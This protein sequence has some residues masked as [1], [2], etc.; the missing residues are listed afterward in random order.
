MRLTDRFKKAV[1]LW[2]PREAYITLRR[3]LQDEGAAESLRGVLRKYPDAARWEKQGDMQP[4]RY[5]LWVRHFKAADIL[6]EHTPS[7]LEDKNEQGHTLLH[8]YAQRCDLKPLVFLLRQGADMNARDLHGRTALHL[9]CMQHYGDDTVSPL[10][11]YGA[12]HD[13]KDR[14]GRTPLMIALMSGNLRAAKALMKKPYSPTQTDIFGR[15][16]LMAAA[17]G[18]MAEVIPA[19]LQSGVNIRQKNPMGETALDLALRKK[20]GQSVLLLLQAYL[21]ALDDKQRRKAGNMIRPLEGS[22][23]VLHKMGLRPSPRKKPAPPRP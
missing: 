16:L 10:L 8:T 17:E 18:G 3:A 9:S 20:N 19:L 12:Q 15:T 5:A 23:D 6:I 7:I 4:L 1:G 14:D 2:P 13:I 21:P 22:L 11:H